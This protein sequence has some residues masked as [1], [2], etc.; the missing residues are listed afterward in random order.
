MRFRIVFSI[1]GKRRFLPINYQYEL[2]AWIYKRI[3]SADADY[4]QFLHSQGYGDFNRRY[5][6]FSFSP[7]EIRP[8]R[9]HREYSAFELLGTEVALTF[10]FYSEIAAGAFIKGIF[11]DQH[12]GL[13]NRLHQVDMQ[14]SRVEAL[15]EPHFSETMEWQAL[16]PVVVSVH[17]EG[18][19]HAQYAHPAQV[20]YGQAI[21]QNL[22]SRWTAYHTE[23][24]LVPLDA[25]EHNK[26][27]NNTAFELLI[28]KP[29]AKLITIK[30]LTP[31]ET[32]VKG[33]LYHFKLTAP[34]ELQRLV[35]ASGVGEK[36][37]LGFGFIKRSG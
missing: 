9:L 28:D 5:K 10:G 15:P 11:M 8:F 36:G 31:Q 33:Y 13:G 32:K 17:T 35:Y 30:A 27:V 22:I 4:A 12:I 21:I 23:Q 16:S 2:S 20:G 18:K 3:A 19:K 7:L 1:T 25:G 34:I 24:E 6:L 29:K 14:V 37:S 26:E